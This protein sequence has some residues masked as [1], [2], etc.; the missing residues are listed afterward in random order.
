MNRGLKNRLLAIARQEI[1]GDDPS[2][3]FEHALRVMKN[4][5]IIAKREGGDLDVIIPAALFHDLIVYPKDS[6][7][8]EH[9]SEVSARKTQAILKKIKVFP[10]NKI[11]LVASCIRNCSFSKGIN[12]T[13]REAQIVQDADWLEATGAVSIM[14]TYSSTGQMERP[15]YNTGDPFAIQRQPDSTKYALDL[16]FTR[17]L[18][19]EKRMYTATAKR[20]AKRRTRFLKQFL[21]ELKLELAGK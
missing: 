19:V 8:S 7:H 1:K 9:S 13:A 18:V 10:Q 12:H 2:H 20:I 6:R 17:L 11:K 14:R 21:S 4:V 15:F 5:E 16:F 3:D